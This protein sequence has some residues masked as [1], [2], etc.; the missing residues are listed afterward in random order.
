MNKVDLY[1]WQEEAVSKLKNKNGLLCVPTGEG[2]TAVAKAWADL[3]NADSVIFT[4]P[5]KAISNERYIEL[6]DEG[7]DVGL[8][9]GDCVINPNARILCMTQEIY[10]DRYAEFGNQRV[11]FDEIGY[12][13]RDKD[14][15]QAY[16]DGL[17]KTPESSK[18]LCMSATIGNIEELKDWLEDAKHGDPF[19]VYESV[20]R[21]KEIYTHRAFDFDNEPIKANSLV[22]AFTIS[23]C[24]YM[25]RQIVDD[26]LSRLQDDPSREYDINYI[27]NEKGDGYDLER[28]KKIKELIEICGLQ[29]KAKNDEEWA[30]QIGMGV[31]TYYGKMSFNEKIFIETAMKA[32]LIDIIVGTDALALGVNL[33]CKNTYITDTQKAGK[34]LTNSE[35]IQMA[36]RAGRDKK[37][38]EGHLYLSEGFEYLYDYEKDEVINIPEKISEMKAEDIALETFS[39]NGKINKD[40]LLKMFNV[41]SGDYY[42][43]NDPVMYIIGGFD[44]NY[45]D[46]GYSPNALFEALKYRSWS[47]NPQEELGSERIDLIEQLEKISEKYNHELISDVDNQIYE[48]KYSE[49]EN[50]E[51]YENLLDQLKCFTEVLNKKDFYVFPEINQGRGENSGTAV[52]RFIGF[53]EQI[54][55]FAESEENN[56]DDFKISTFIGGK[57]SL[58]GFISEKMDDFERAKCHVEGIK[59]SELND[60]QPECVELLKWCACHVQQINELADKLDV[61]KNE[62]DNELN[63]LYKKRTQICKERNEAY[64]SVLAECLKGYNLTSINYDDPFNNIVDVIN[65]AFDVTP[66]QKDKYVGAEQ[67]IIGT[68]DFIKKNT[69]YETSRDN[70]NKKLMSFDEEVDQF[71]LSES[72]NGDLELSSFEDIESEV[73]DEM[74]NNANSGADKKKMHIND[75]QEYIQ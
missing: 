14:R 4:A 51:D 33:P 47:L 55:T 57:Y 75:N 68:Y 17:A 61:K 70:E 46:Y 34:N 3:D 71:E 7:Y 29:D 62:L 23:N 74:K 24:E 22:F 39:H 18:I 67:L 28:L 53:I 54:K 30:N 19:S 36:G 12:I 15:Q 35:I 58:S 25:A 52:E 1:P 50:P 63:I 6:F 20:H 27:I 26:R 42:E 11:I 66:E 65:H 59:Y 43:Y 44:D 38:T 60:K 10:T 13:G 41:L 40:T 69:S 72:I 56:I 16:F 49:D 37:Y 32:G 5:I 64:A 9:T 8:I 48:R 45:D 21:S 73:L 31:G 2:K